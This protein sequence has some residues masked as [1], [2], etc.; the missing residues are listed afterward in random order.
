[1]EVEHIKT[2]GF[3]GSAILTKLGSSLAQTG[4]GDKN[5]SEWIE[6]GGTTLSIVLLILGL[7]YLKTKLENREKRL[8]ELHNAS[9]KSNEKSTEA[10]I[11]LA[12]ALDKLADKIDRK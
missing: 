3:F 5:I 8:D 11:Q 7:R 12:Q 4:I 2:A 9:I 10:R 1:M 6:R